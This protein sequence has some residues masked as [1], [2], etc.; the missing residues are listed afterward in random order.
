MCSS[1][2][3]LNNWISFLHIGAADNQTEQVLNETLSYQNVQYMV[4]LKNLSWDDAMAACINNKM[5]L[6][7][8]TDQF[9]QAFLAVQAALRNY[10]LWIGLFSRDVSLVLFLFRLCL[11]VI[12]RVLWNRN[13]DKEMQ[14][15]INFWGNCFHLGITIWRVSRL[16][17]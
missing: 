11:E 5:Q 3:P 9:Q 2:S 4:I 14:W 17:F 13:W 7:S 10:P 6:V 12:F 1:V 15:K 16:M 8:I